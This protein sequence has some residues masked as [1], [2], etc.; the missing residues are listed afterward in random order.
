MLDVNDLDEAIAREV[1]PYL[2]VESR[3]LIRSGRDEGDPDFVV[4]MT[5]QFALLDSV[6]IPMEILDAI[7]VDLADDGGVCGRR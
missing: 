1:E 7:A 3:A 6:I 5:L 2:T 4:Y